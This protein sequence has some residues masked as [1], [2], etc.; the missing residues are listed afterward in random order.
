MKHILL[1]ILYAFLAFIFMLASVA[2]IFIS[3]E[4]VVGLC[5][6][7]AALCFGG[8]MCGEIY[9]YMKE[10]KTKKQIKTQN[11]KLEKYYEDIKNGIWKFPCEKFYNKCCEENLVNFDNEFSIKKGYQIVYEILSEY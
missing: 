6:G 2:L 11:E 7:F 3:E 4:Y 1:S 10:K 5:L 9:F 8:M